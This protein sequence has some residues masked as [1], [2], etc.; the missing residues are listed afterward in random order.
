METLNLR[1]FIEQ[2]VITTAEAAEILQITKQRMINIVRSGDIVPVKNTKQGMLFLRADID[3]YKKRRDYGIDDKFNIASVPIYDYSGSTRKSIN[4]FKENRKNIGEIIAI[5]VY[6]EEYDAAMDSFYIPSENERYGD[7]RIINAPHMVIRDI[8]GREIWLGGCNS[9]YGG[10]G[11]HGT[12]RI[13]NMLKKSG[14]LNISED[15][16]EKVL[17]NRIVKI[18]KDEN[19]KIEFITHESP[20]EK[21]K[22]IFYSNNLELYYFRNN[23]VL[24]QDT[25]SMWNESDVS[26]LEIY[27]NFIPNPIQVKIFQTHK[28]AKEEGYVKPG[29]AFSESSYRLI[30]FDESG[31][32]VWL[33]PYVDDTKAISYQNNLVQMLK[34]C[35]FDIKPENLVEKLRRWVNT[36]VR[37]IPTDPI[38]IK[39]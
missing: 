8:S 23:L 24:V 15:D 11:P 10:E 5:F 21:K 2:N 28:Q 26:D 25:H 36:N 35:G 20:L 32:Q 9:G 22:T 18:F 1:K 4:F 12:I 3:A 27:Q 6:F 37:K 16:I 30:I 29:S 38:I 31:R 14:D 34:Y 13:L 7:L 33:D 19:G 39:K 17:Y